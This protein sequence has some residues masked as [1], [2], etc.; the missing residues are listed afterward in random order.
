MG[1]L[2]AIV[3]VYLRRIYY[4]GGFGFPLVVMDAAI[5]RAE[6]IREAM[7]LVMLGCLAWIAAERAWARLLAFLVAFGVWDIAY[8]VGLKLF[9]GWPAH[10]LEPDILFLL[11]VVWIGP[12]LAPLLVAGSWS[13]AGLLLHRYRYADL[14][15]GW[16]EW[17][18][19]AAAHGLMLASFL[20]HA[21]TQEDPGFRWPLFLAGYALGL[22]VL[23][24]TL[25]RLRRGPG[26]A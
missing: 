21:G 17:V 20:I 14:G 2:E 7:T 1:I 8:Y 13:A 12:V 10:L 23:V 22:A 4:P 6:L 24:V 18:G 26:R 9:L 16:R 15:W 25:L 11:P 3:V 19:L 5:L